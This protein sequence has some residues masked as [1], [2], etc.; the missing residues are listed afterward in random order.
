MREMGRIYCSFDKYTHAVDD[1]KE[2][3]EIVHMHIWWIVRW[4]WLISFSEPFFLSR[5][6]ISPLSL[7]LFL[8]LSHTLISLPSPYLMR[9]LLF[10]SFCTMLCVCAL[11][12]CMYVFVC[13][14]HI[15]RIY[16]II[17]NQLDCWEIN[18]LHKH[19]FHMIFFN[20]FTLR[21]I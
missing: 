1:E 16:S 19:L 4:L 9:E 12:V 14:K 2:M 18:C 13:R 15:Y 5:E 7:S 21:S 10:F 17:N 20:H 6:V 11:M 3:F 8:S